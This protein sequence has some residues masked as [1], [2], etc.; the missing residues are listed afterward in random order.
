M[1]P[2][3]LLRYANG[4][5]LLLIIVATA[6]V[7][8]DL[9]GYRLKSLFRNAPTTPASPA[10][11]PAATDLL[12]FSSILTN[13]LFGPATV[14][15]LTPIEA[16]PA[17]S[18]KGEA[19]AAPPSDLTLLGT[20]RGSFRETFVLVRKNSTGEERVFRL[21][22]DLFGSGKLIRVGKESMTLLAG[23]RTVM[24]AMPTAPESAP[25]STPASP[26][27]Q[28]SNPSPPASAGVTSTGS[29]SFIIDK[30]AL[31]AALDNISQAMTDARL[32]P[33]MKDG[34]VEGFRASEV[35][36]QGVFGMVGVRNGDIIAR[37]ND[38]PID[39]PDK[40]MQAFMTLKGQSRIK[41]DLIRDGRPTTFTYDIR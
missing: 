19:P 32:L 23:G 20:A 8:G 21:G 41:L 25:P 13:G 12:S 11:S 17:G 6:R 18:R 40:A 15:T 9:A 27:P 35:K 1:S 5:L 4:C 7:G 34:K 24:V 38:F 36:P 30:R 33:S 31:D 28:A 29:G 16:S 22:D 26:H 14:G 37:I 3:T 2:S 39:S 10:P